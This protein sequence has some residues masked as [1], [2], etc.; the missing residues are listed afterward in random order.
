MAK[1]HLV[2]LYNTLLNPY[3]NYGVIL[4]GASGTTKLKKIKVMQ[5]KAMRAITSSKYNESMREKYKQMGI[6]QIDNLYTLNLTKL[7]FKQKH[8]TPS[9]TKAIYLKHY[10]SF[11]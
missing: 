4:W 5:N 1:E 8:V 6:M 10:G 3:L 2:K 11:I 7:M 9:N